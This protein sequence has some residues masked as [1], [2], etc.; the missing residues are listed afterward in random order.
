[1]LS[2]ALRLGP[3]GCAECLLCAAKLEHFLEESG[4]ELTPPV[5]EQ[6]AG[7]PRNRKMFWKYLAVAAA[8]IGKSLLGSYLHG[9]KLVSLVQLHSMQRA[10]Q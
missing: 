6:E 5:C 9:M 2:E 8:P 7:S 1:M 4:G 3:V 10:G